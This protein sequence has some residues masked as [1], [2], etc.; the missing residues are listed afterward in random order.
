VPYAKCPFL[1][2]TLVSMAIR[3]S[4]TISDDLNELG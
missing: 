1:G 3:S 4:L 2:L